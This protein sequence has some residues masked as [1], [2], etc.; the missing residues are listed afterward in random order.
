MMRRKLCVSTS[1][2]SFHI[3]KTQL[4]TCPSVHHDLPQPTSL[5]SFLFTEK[6][7]I[8]LNRISDRPKVS[9]RYTISLSWCYIWSN[10]LGPHLQCGSELQF[11]EFQVSHWPTRVL[12]KASVPKARSSRNGF[13]HLLGHSWN[14]QKKF[15]CGY[16]NIDENQKIVRSCTVFNMMGWKVQFKSICFKDDWQRVWLI[17]PPH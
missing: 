16:S 5:I 3:R 4:H 12:R 8:I 11:K 2:V 1:A 15:H 10:N 6:F 17:D 7:N 9:R 13:P 14:I